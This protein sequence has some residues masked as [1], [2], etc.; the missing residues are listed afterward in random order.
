MR[1]AVSGPG[2][3]ICGRL[4][5][6][7][8]DPRQNCPLNTSPGSTSKTYQYDTARKGPYTPG[9]RAE[10]PTRTLPPE[11]P[12]V[13][14]GTAPSGASSTERQAKAPFRAAIRQ[15]YLARLCWSPNAWVLAQWTSRIQLQQNLWPA[16]PVLLLAYY[17]IIRL[18]VRNCWRPV[19]LW[20][21]TLINIFINIMSGTVR[22]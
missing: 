8:S 6:S 20:E 18:G 5:S 21:E 14:V 10:T 1:L 4:N 15:N 13:P 2:C 3:S 11:T 9:L 7:S 19:D 17:P 22:L 12:H 16:Y